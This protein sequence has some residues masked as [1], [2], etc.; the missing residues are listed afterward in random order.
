MVKIPVTVYEEIKS[1]YIEFE[2]G[3]NQHYSSSLV[4]YITKQ[5]KPET[6]EWHDVNGINTPYLVTVIN[7]KED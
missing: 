6:I 2:G 5:D 1:I 4:G 7:K 3:G